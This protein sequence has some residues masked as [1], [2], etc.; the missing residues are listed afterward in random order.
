MLRKASN[1]F[2]L[3]E[4]NQCYVNFL[5]VGGDFF[6][7]YELKKLKGKVKILNSKILKEIRTGSGQES[8]VNLYQPTNYQWTA[9]IFSESIIR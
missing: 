1:F 5:T 6:S 4:K 9:V 7:P 2:I 8:G 3:T